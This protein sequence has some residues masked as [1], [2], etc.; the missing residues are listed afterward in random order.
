MTT[1][2][3]RIP[4]DRPV[5]SVEFM[6]PRDDADELRL[7]NA[8]RSLEGLDPAFVSV[9]YGAGGS[10][11]DRTI[12]TTGRVVTETTLVSM[13]HLTAV[14]Q[15]VA[16]LR[17]V[18]GWYASI[19][20]RN[21]LAVRGDPPGDPNGEWVRHPQGLEY[22]E[23]LVRLVRSLGDFCVGVSAFPYGHPRSGDLDTDTKYLVRKLNAGADFAIAQL[24]FEADDFLRLRDRVAAAGC[25]TLLLPGVM[26]LTTPKI[27]GKTV[28][29][30][31]APVPAAL[32]AR[33]DPLADD[34]KSFR[35]EG[36]DVTTEL[37][38]RL[39]AEGVPGLH[40]YTF[41]RSKAT[42]EIVVERLGLVPGRTAQPVG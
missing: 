11:R 39:L 29:L 37:C 21:V 38:E 26:P 3:D 36:M 12:R 5:F 34:A 33:L 2:V 8:I 31:G 20:I 13:A 16:E 18:I 27:L 7:W 30:S 10:S 22:A 35:E 28:E 40:F 19:G 32:A 24:F 23:E 6:P 25:E 42:K 14:D 9:T 15:S 17:N 1:V 41:N 4:G